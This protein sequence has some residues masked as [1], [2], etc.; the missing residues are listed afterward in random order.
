MFGVIIAVLRS[1]GAAFQPRRQ[2]VLENLALR[3]QLLVLSRNAKKPRF[4]NPDRLLWVVLR[5]VWARWEKALVIIQPQTVIGW[6]RAGF[7]RYWRWKSRRRDGRPSLEPELIQLIR[8]MWQANPTWG[9]PRIRDE[10]AK[11][12]LQVSDSTIRKYRPK[13]QRPSSQAWKTFLHN[14]T[15]QIAAV[16]F[17]T[18]PTATFRV[19]FVFIVL[20]HKRR[21]V[22]HFAVT[23]SPSA[24]WA[25]QQLVNA[26]PFEMAPKFLLRDR[27]SIYGTEFMRRVAGLGMH[28]KLITP[29]SPWQ[30]PYVERLIGTL[31]RECLDHVIIFNDRQLERVLREYVEYYHA[32]RTHR[33]LEHDCPLP[34]PIE[35]PGQGKIVELPWVG[36]LHHRYTR[37]AA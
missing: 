33:A 31:R 25:G 13:P 14:H 29:R 15:T 10:L 6:H 4:R 12:G 16:D 24:F 30:N 11:L 34:R 21:K 5:A 28:E 37:Q 8:R 9:S 7:R 26:F 23:E 19:L 35:A 20:A 36:G 1:L 17:F 3:H 22:V 27:D 18:V 2:L 32:H